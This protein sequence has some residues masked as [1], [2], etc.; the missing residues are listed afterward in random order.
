MALMLLLNDVGVS[1]SHPMCMLKWRATSIKKITSIIENFAV[2]EMQTKVRL[3][4]FGI[5]R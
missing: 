2:V 3:F 5:K 1:H 4:Y